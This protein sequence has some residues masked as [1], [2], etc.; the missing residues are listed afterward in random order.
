MCRSARI[1]SPPYI[2]LLLL[3]GCAQMETTPPASGNAGNGVAGTGGDGSAG[4]VGATGAGG[5][6]TGVAGNGVAG[7]D[8]G[9]AGA[10]GSPAGRG[11][12]QSGSPG[13]QS[14]AAGRG[15]AAGGGVA[16][17]G[18]GA[19]CTIVPATTMSTQIPT[20]AV[21]TFT[22]TLTGVTGASIQFG[23]PGATPMVAPVDTAAVYYRTL[24]L[25]MKANRDYVYRIVVNS[26]AGSCTSQ[27]VMIH[28]GNLPTTGAPP[29]PART[30]PMPAAHAPGFI[31]TS[32]GTTTGGGSAVVPVYILDGDGD[33]V[34]WAAAPATCSR[35]H[36]S[37]DGKEMWMQELNVDNAGGE[38]RKIA[39]DGTGAMNNIVGLNT[40]HHDFTVLPDGGI[41][42]MLWSSS[43]MDAP[44][45]LIERSASGQMTT[46]IP[47]LNTIYRSTA[48]YHANAIHYYPSDDSYTIS[49]RNVNLF[50]KVKRNGQLVWQLGGSNPIGQA[51]TI[52]GGTWQVNHGHHLL[53]NG[54]FLF[55]TNGPFNGSPPSQAL[56][57]SLNTT[58]WT[59]TR[60]WAYQASGV[61]SPVLSDVQRLPNGNTLVTYSVPGTIHEVSPTGQLVMSLDTASVGYAEYRDSLY[62]PPLR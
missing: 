33:P 55:F 19:A 48:G 47:N 39:M 40:S 11:G 31:I 8:G 50:V 59:A 7:S 9:Q 21:V 41:A 3:F 2:G 42:T 52:T 5:N 61:N 51:F 12:G 56:E 44:N 6:A 54:N 45:S 30:I 62:G 35:A 29:K 15:G 17:S 18:G 46:I 38:M 34:W 36:M 27:D 1:A 23:L 25:G 16:G 14:G 20:V 37:W 22:T 26:A 32:G 60:V 10:A 53:P 49:D 24:L 57:Y 4:G 28:T 58:S 13:G 43:G